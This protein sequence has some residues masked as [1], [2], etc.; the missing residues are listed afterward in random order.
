MESAWNTRERLGRRRCTSVRREQA[1]L[2]R[3]AL[4]SEQL[5][6]NRTREYLGEERWNGVSELSLD[7]TPGTSHDNVIGERLEAT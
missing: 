3:E 6:A 2:R 4:Q 7:G 5:R 1:W